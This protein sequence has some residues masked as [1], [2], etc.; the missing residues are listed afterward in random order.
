[1][2]LPYRQGSSKI[3]IYFHG[4]GVDIGISRE[5]CLKIKDR[6][7]AHVLAMEYPGYGIYEGKPDSN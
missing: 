2:F 5:Q 4:N 6:M 7:K 1:L 3:I